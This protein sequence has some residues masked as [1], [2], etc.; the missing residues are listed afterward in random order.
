MTAIRNFPNAPARFQPRPLLL[1]WHVPAWASK[2][3]QALHDHARH[4][5][6]RELEMLADRRALADPVL[7]RQL[8][9][10]AAECRRITWLPTRPTSRSPS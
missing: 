7:A 6:A 3:W 8:R 5:A 10:A 9:D 4:R 2:V 1:R